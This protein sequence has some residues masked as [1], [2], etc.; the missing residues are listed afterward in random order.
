MQ[1]SLLK[2]KD[3]AEDMGKVPT[4]GQFGLSLFLWEC[5]CRPQAAGMLLLLTESKD[6]QAQSHLSLQSTQGALLA[7]KKVS[8]QFVAIVRS[9]TFRCFGSPLPWHTFLATHLLW[10]TAQVRSSQDM[11]DSKSPGH[12]ILAWCP[13]R[14]AVTHLQKLGTDFELRCFHALTPCHPLALLNA[15]EEVP[16]GPRDDALLLLRDVHVKAS[17]HGVGLP[18][19]SLQRQR[20]RSWLD[21]SRLSFAHYTPELPLPP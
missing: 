14:P 16:D 13:P 21:S 4:E 5:W 19:T 7:T 3:A 18:C 12:G 9:T 17:A 10:G 20:G 1:C 8:P 11:E 15:T 2:V 6:E